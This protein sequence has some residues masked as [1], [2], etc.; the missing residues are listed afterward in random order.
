MA[1]WGINEITLLDSIGNLAA[2]DPALF[3]AMPVEA[4]VAQ[5]PPVLPTVTIVGSSGDNQ[6]FDDLIIRQ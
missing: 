6:L 2:A 5:T 3:A 1:K 4:P